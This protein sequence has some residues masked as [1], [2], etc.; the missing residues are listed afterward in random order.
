[1]RPR[2]IIANFPL[3]GRLIYP[4]KNRGSVFKDASQFYGKAL[5]KPFRPKGNSKIVIFGLPK[6][7]NVWLLNLISDSL[8][9]NRVDFRKHKS[10]PGVSMIHDALNRRIL[11]RSDI[12]RG[13]YLIRDVRDIV[14]SYFHYSKTEEYHQDFIDPFCHYE[15]I[16]RFYFEY[17]LNV[18]VPK[19]DW[20]NHP[21]TYVSSGLPMVRYEAL[22]DDP[23]KEMH[24][25]FKKL[26]IE[27]EEAKIDSAIC[28]ND[29]SVLSKK[30][31]EINLGKQIPKSHFR[32]GGYGN[33]KN[34]LPQKV[35]NH[36]NFH[37]KDYLLKWGYDLDM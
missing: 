8:D 24:L 7:G 1:M 3:I 10:K 30:G 34:V 28:N 20:L 16:E 6:S 31:K 4:K 33:Y 27:V 23:K 21:E 19:Y 35:L 12:K 37:F 32:K 29:I 17:F 26:G 36:I 11:L 5:L 25:L 2:T 13:V 15:D 9:I 14:V 18:I 22:W